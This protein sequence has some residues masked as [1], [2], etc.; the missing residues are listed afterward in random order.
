M[1]RSSPLDRL[2]TLPMQDADITIKPRDVMPAGATTLPADFYTD[3]GRFRVEM[4][5]LF[6]QHWICAGRVDRSSRLASSSFAS[7]PVR[8]S[9]SREARQGRVQAFYNVCRHRGTR[10]CTEAAGRFAGSI[11]CPYHAWTYALDGR[12]VGAPH[13]DE[14]PHFRKE[15]YPLHRVEANEWDGH[16]FI[17]LAR[18][19]RPLVRS[20]RRSARKVQ[21][22]AHAGSSARPPHRVRRARELEADRPELQRVPALPEPSPGAQQTVALSERRERAA[23]RLVHG[24][25]DGPSTG[26]GDHVDGWHLSAR[27]TC[28]SSP[29][30][31]VE[32]L[33]T[34][35]SSRTCSSACTRTT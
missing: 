20:T 12:L 14:V 21:I 22:V 19:P 17:T 24:R 25:P 5:R 30:P 3:Q 13:M 4:D 15:D 7:P 29:R 34:T 10:L 9:S 18:A 6:M 23:P 28:R 11:Q 16:I 31:S 2:K 1:A 33:T 27:G 8:A 26:R 35:R 32:G